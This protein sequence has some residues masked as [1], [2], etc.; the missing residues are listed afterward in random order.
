MQP[1]Y[2]E[3]HPMRVLFKIT[4]SDPPG[5][6]CKSNWFEN[7]IILVV[8]N[9]YPDFVDENVMDYISLSFVS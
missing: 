6:S 3:M 9:L 5:L 4:K 2:H 1:P 8:L 7:T